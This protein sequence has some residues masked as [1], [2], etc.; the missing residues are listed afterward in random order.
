VGWVTPWTIERF[1]QTG[2]SENLCRDLCRN[3]VIPAPVVAYCL[4]SLDLKRRVGNYAQA[5]MNIGVGYHCDF[6]GVTRSSF[7][8]RIRDQ[9]VGGSNPLSPTNLFK[10]QPG[11]MGYT[12]YRLHG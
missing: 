10:V 6:V 1:G 3:R 11:H 9:G 4:V 2:Q 8:H 12:M 5:R 7:G